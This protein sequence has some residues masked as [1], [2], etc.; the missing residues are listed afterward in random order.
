MSSMKI[1]NNTKRAA[2]ILAVLTGSLGLTLSS[3]ALPLTWLDGPQAGQAFTGGGIQIKAINFDTGTLY[4]AQPVG[5]AIGFGV[6]GS[7]ASVAAGQAALNATPGRA[8][9]GG[10][11]GEDSWGIMQI[12]Q[13]NAIASDG[14]RHVIYD[15]IAS[16]FELTALFWAEQDFYL[17]QISAGSGFAP[18]GQLIDGSGLRVDIYSDAVK[19]FSQ[20]A[21]PAG[22]PGNLYPT[23]TDGNLE[24]SLLSTPGFINANGTFGGAAT[25]F[26]SNTANTGYAALNVIG[27][28]SAAQ[29]NTNAV[30]FGGSTGAL[31]TP[32]VAGQSSTDV[33]FQ[34]TTG[35]G[36]SG[37]DVTSNDPMTAS[38]AGP[39]VADSGSTLVMLGL[40]MAFLAEAYRRR[41][42]HA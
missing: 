18:A 30:G 2:G 28:A 24:L 7:S 14:V 34:F 10:S 37:W 1:L 36:V 27:G 29:F 5:T 31:F 11:G 4:N 21:G 23:V 12:T 40:G 8:I 26:E 39:S 13:I 32:G 41:N 15:S 22:H 19:N 33:F 3:N 20:T 17:S 25:E 35:Q 42:R 38:I 16:P 6:G 9:I